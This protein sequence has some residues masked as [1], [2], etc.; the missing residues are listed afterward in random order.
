MLHLGI[1]YSC[2]PSPDTFTSSKT[3]AGNKVVTAS[4]LNMGKATY[5]NYCISCHGAGGAGDGVSSIGMF[6]PPRNL[7]QGMYKFANVVSGGLPHDED[8]YRIIRKGL[9]GSAMLP[10]DI[11]DERLDAV[12]QYIKTFAPKN[13]EGA[14]KPLGE[15]LEL[16]KDPYG[17]QNKLEA[18]A[19]GKKLYHITAACT[20]CHR[21]YE[22]KENI[23]KFSQEINN[24]PIAPEDFAADFY[25][26]KALGSAYNYQVIV[27]DFTYHDLR[28]I[29]TTASITESIMQRLIYGVNGSGMPS[30]KDVVTDDQLWEIAYYVQSLIELKNSKERDNLVKNLE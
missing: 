3:F 16:P 8:F 19:K 12:T 4:T 18:I 10:W 17:E 13:W 27:P 7:T 26:V 1:Y 2:T 23:S 11:S 22:T 28:T 29:G 14:D 24:S 30:F 25:Q 5:E 9:H 21:G 6:P 20:A 15:K